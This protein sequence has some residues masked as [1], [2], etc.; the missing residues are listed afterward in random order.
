MK[1]KKDPTTLEVF[2]SLVLLL[3]LL[4]NPRFPFA[5][6][7]GSRAPHKEGEIRTKPDHEINTQE[8]NTSTRLSGKRALNTC[9][10]LPPET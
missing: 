7:K 2:F 3:F 10:L 8:H 5:Y 1:E 6:K 4:C 9:S